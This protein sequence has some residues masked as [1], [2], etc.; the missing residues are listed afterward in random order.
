MAPLRFLRGM[1]KEGVG[2]GRDPSEPTR[3]AGPKSP[4]RSHNLGFWRLKLR[5]SCRDGDGDKS[6][7]WHRVPSVQAPCKCPGQGHGGGFVW[8][9]PKIL[10]CRMTRRH[11]LLQQEPPKSWAAPDLSIPLEQDCFLPPW[12]PSEATRTWLTLKVSTILKS[13][14]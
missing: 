11:S 6:Q 2:A 10:R 13:Q 1:R 8:S 3:C 14:Q 4:A 7:Q 9:H 5:A 12:R